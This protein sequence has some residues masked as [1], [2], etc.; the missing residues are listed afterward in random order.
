MQKTHRPEKKQ[1]PFPASI[2]HFTFDIVQHVYFTIE[3]SMR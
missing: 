2:E 1:L 3:I